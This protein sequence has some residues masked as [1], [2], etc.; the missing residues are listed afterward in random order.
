MAGII[1]AEVELH[2]RPQGHGYAIVEV[3]VRN[4]WFPAGSCIKGHEF[5]Y[6]RLINSGNLSTVFNIK[7]G[8]GIN[9]TM[10]GIVYK[11]MLAS[12]L[13]INALGTPKW[14]ESFISLAL[15]FAKSTKLVAT[16]G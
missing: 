8:H 9:G 16:Y 10:D 4:P 15:N 13:H 7:R 6:S 1:P 12:Y 3:A 2:A 5:H 11:N 14:A